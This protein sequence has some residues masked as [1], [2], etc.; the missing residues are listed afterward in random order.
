MI[1]C[2]CGHKT[3]TPKREPKEW[4]D[5]PGLFS[6][7]CPKCE[8]SMILIKDQGEW[9]KATRDEIRKAMKK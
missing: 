9:R 5:M 2:K 4:S 7:E 3:K 1:E 6:G 8:T